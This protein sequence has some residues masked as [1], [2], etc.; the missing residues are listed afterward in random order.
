MD[1]EIASFE[2]SDALGC[3]APR[4]WRKRDFFVAKN[5]LTRQI[6]SSADKKLF[7]S[8]GSNRPI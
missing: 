7:Q 3:T 2:C 8:I 4:E 5:T 1:W 6:I